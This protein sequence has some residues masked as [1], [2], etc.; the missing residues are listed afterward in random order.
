MKKSTKIV[1]GSIAGGCVLL[2]GGCTLM[3]GAAVNEVD[4]S[5]K[6]DEA[7]DKRAADQ[8][9]KITKCEVTEEEF[10]GKDLSA[11]VEIT[12]NGEKRANYLVE[13]EL[14]S[15]DGNKIGELLASVENLAPGKSSSQNFGGL[16][17]SEDL[18]GVEI[19]KADCSMVNVS[20]DE[21]LA[22]ND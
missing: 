7:D 12:N 8:D 1:L 2:F 21:W 17:T 13:G 16:F 15:S 20:R 6:A 4:K 11:R 5:I 18:K 19:G 10:L 14:L 22:A 9:V 3:V